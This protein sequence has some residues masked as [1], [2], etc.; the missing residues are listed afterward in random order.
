MDDPFTLASVGAT[1]LA[2]GVT[3]FYDQ[4][5]ELLRQTRERRAAA[6]GETSPRI[7]IELPPAFDTPS[8]EAHV[9]DDFVEARAGALSVVR[10]RLAP[11][12]EG[13]LPVRPEDEWLVREVAALRDLVER[14]LRVSLT[15]RGESRGPSGAPVVRGTVHAR[16]VSARATV[17]AVD[18]E[19][20][21]GAASVLGETV[22]DEDVA[23]GAEV[24]GVR[25][26]RIGGS[27]A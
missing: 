18:A 22:V 26:R 21:D 1:V 10:T 25:V 12:A 2:A 4:A 20:V 24:Y 9:D 14:S 16:H 11:Y 8:V 7:R 3:F 23:A 17:A 27:T 15:L 5:G 6:A 19:Q 13:A